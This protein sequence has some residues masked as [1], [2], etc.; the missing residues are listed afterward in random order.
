MPRTKNCNKRLP[1]T[2]YAG[3]PAATD[4]TARTKTHTGIK[5]CSVKWSD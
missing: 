2:P 1:L 5:G 4:P 3:K